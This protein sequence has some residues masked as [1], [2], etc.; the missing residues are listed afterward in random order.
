VAVDERHPEG[1]RLRH[2]HERVVDGRVTVRMQLAHDLA[3]DAGR[4][5]VAAIGS[6]AH[7][8]HLVEDAPLHR[9]QPVAR[10]GQ[11]PGVDDG[12]GVFEKRA[13][14]LGGDVDIFDAFGDRVVCGRVLCSGHP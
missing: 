14:H 6:Q 12:V 10:V 13:L 5:H 4:L 8:V 3:D 11:R 2:A 9:L 7:L 1:E